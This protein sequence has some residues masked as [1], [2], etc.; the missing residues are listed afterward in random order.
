MTFVSADTPCTRSGA[1]VRCELGTAGRGDPQRGRPGEGRPA[2]GRGRRPPAPVRRAEDRGPRGHR[3]RGPGHRHRR[4]PAPGTSCTDGSGRID[5]VDQGTGTLRGRADDRE[6][7][8]S[9]PT[10]GGRTSSTTRRVGRRPR[11]SRSASRPRARSSTATATTW[12]SGDQMT[13]THAAAGRPTDVTLTCAPGQTPVAAGLPARRRGAGRHDVP[14]RRQRLDLGCGQPRGRP[15]RAR[16]PCA[17]WT[18]WSAGRRPH[19]RS[20]VSTRCRQTRHRPAG[21][22]GRGHAQLRGRRQ[23]HRGRLRRR[24]GAGRAGQRPAADHAGVQVLQPD[25]RAARGRLLPALPGQ[26]HAEGGRPGRERGEHGDGQHL[27]A[28]DVDR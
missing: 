5:H 13:E 7:R 14:R 16:S 1:N 20:S 23:G 21:P 11:S 6:P 26:P 19:A 18:T 17:V 10:A 2:A 15:A 12:W 28:G 22:A 24:R 4:L 27:D 25:R 8:R 9:V 3:G